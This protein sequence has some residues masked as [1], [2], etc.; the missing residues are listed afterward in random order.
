MGS[1]LGNFKGVGSAR[2]V[3]NSEFR[4]TKSKKPHQDE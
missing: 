2:F 3:K 4:A 1:S